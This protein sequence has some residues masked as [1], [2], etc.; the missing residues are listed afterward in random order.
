MVHTVWEEFHEMDNVSM[1][2][3]YVHFSS[4]RRV[5]VCQMDSLSIHGRVL[6]VPARLAAQH[7]SGWR[8]SRSLSHTTDFT[9][10]RAL[11]CSCLQL[12]CCSSPVQPPPPRLLLSALS[13]L[14]SFLLPLPRVPSPSSLSAL[15]RRYL[16]PLICSL[17]G[18]AE[19]A[20]YSMTLAR[21]NQRDKGKTRRV[22]RTALKEMVYVWESLW[23]NVKM[24]V[25]WT[26][27]LEMLKFNHGD[28]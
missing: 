12:S 5:C 24:H 22:E 23:E 1:F 17:N 27:I 26:T 9:C 3:V 13:S 18:P 19:P 4:L 6:H 11:S 10:S 28:Y 21:V 20:C 25:D 15:I 8:D 16:S 7:C 2:S 14:V